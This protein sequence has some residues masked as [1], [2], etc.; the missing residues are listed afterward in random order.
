MKNVSTLKSAL[1]VVGGS[2][3]AMPASALELGE[4]KVHSALGQPLRASISY[5]L[6]PNE[7]ISDTCVSLVPA[8]ASGGLPS[9]DRASIIVADGVI[10]ITG[11]AIVRELMMSLGL[12]IRCH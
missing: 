12:G 4:L 11:S 10:A 5:A 1:V 2:I 6:G 8:T 3:A 9:I 7:A